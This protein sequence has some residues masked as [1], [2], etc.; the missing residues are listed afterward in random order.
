MT[1]NLNSHFISQDDRKHVQP[2][3]LARLSNTWTAF[4]ASNAFE[5][6]AHIAR[7]STSRPCHEHSVVR[8]V[9]SEAEPRHRDTAQHP[10]WITLAIKRGSKVIVLCLPSLKTTK[11]SRTRRASTTSRPPFVPLSLF[12]TTA[13][14][15]WQAV[16][17]F[18][19]T[20]LAHRLRGL[21]LNVTAA[22][23]KLQMY[24][25]RERAANIFT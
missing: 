17:H 4:A 13:S 15:T 18:T 21:K 2:L 9:A 8:V 16:I 3:R 25:P 12:Q 23:M 14:E 20:H 19:N 1:N 11:P 24:N 7:T 22:D 10:L 5:V 6:R